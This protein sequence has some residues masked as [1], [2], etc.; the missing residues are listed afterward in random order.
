MGIGANLVKFLKDNWLSLSLLLAIII[1]AC[2]GMILKNLGQWNNRGI[3]YVG[4][5]GEIFMNLLKG[6]SVPLTMSCIIIAFGTL[7]TKLAKSFG[8]QVFLFIVLTKIL[9]TTIG[10]FSAILIQP[11]KHGAVVERKEKIQINYEKE[12]ID[13]FLDMINNVFP[14]N[15]IDIFFRQTTT[16]I[17]RGEGNEPHFATAM[18]HGTNMLGMVSISIFIGLAIK[19]MGDANKPLLDVLLIF[20][21]ITFV[22][23]DLIMISAP[24]LLVFLIAGNALKIEIKEFVTSIGFYALCSSLT[25]L[26]FFFTVY[27][28]ILATFGK[29]NLFK[30]YI[31]NLEAI[32]TAF[33]LGSSMASLPVAI[34]CLDEKLGY[35][36]NLVS[37][38]VPVCIAINKDGAALNLGFTSIFFAQYTH[39]DLLVSDYCLIALFSLTLSLATPGV[40]QGVLIMLIVIL[41]ALD[42]PPDYAGTIIA[43][44][45]I[46]DR[47]VTVI[48]V[49]GAAVAVSVVHNFTRQKRASIHRAPL[50]EEAADKLETNA[51][52][53]SVEAPVE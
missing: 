51:E 41:K 11:G 44:D 36:K 50:E 28:L 35:D 29:V 26:A 39:V 3:M 45:I 20:G 8:M 34:T 14:S 24:L 47:I 43:V 13:N 15:L 32:T 1:G 40:P 2:F 10:M 7:D 6:V 53:A 46:V 17:T 12:T 49:F 48:N 21:R 25:Q 18:I 38:V 9:S 16:N 19:S 31:G 27:P 23:V 33:A 4:F 30:F 5:L 52:D 42:I 22:V 37:F